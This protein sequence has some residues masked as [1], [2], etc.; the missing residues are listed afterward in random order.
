MSAVLLTPLMAATMTGYDV[1]KKSDE[2]QRNFKDEKSISTLKLIDASGDVV[3]RNM[4]SITLERAGKKDLSIIQFLNPADVRGTS[5]LTHQN[6]V[7]DDK[8]WLYLPELKRLKKISSSNKSGSFMGSEFTYEDISANALDKWSYTLIKEEP[9]GDVECYMIEKTPKY[10]N[11]GYSKVKMWIS[12]DNYLLQ[13]AEFFD[14]KHTLLKVQ[15]IEG[16]KKIGRTWRS[17]KIVMHNFQT[18][19]Q[20]HLNFTSRTLGTGLKKKD[21]SKRSVQR[22]I[23]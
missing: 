18:H 21:F 23:K 3:E 13:R 10:T 8:Q 14:R 9:M 22:L 6:P 20:S 7:K 15:T 2:T 4:V 17:D 1:A 16:W 5:L 19:K 11:S 12:K